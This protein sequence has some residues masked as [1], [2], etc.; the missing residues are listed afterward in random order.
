MAKNEADLTGTTR[1]TTPPF[2]E[3]RKNLNGAKSSDFKWVV[4]LGRYHGTAMVRLWSLSFWAKSVMISMSGTAGTAS[5]LSLRNF[6]KK[7][8]LVIKKNI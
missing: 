8:S 2:L 7:R 3:V 6:L 4:P 1:G 5:F